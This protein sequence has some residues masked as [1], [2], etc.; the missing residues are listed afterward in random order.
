MRIIYNIVTL[1][2]FACGMLHA[3]VAPKKGENLWCM[4]ERIGFTSDEILSKVCDIDSY[5]PLDC[6]SQSIA[7]EILMKVCD[8][9]NQNK[10][11]I[12]GTTIAECRE[13]HIN[14]KFQ[15]GISD[16]QVISQT[17]DS[18]VI[19][20]TTVPSM[21]CLELNT[22]QTGRATITSRR[23]IRYRAGHES[24]AV[25]SAAFQ[26]PAS[27]STQWIGAY[28]SVDGAAVGYAD[29]GSFAVLYRVDSINNVINQADFN[30]DTL[31][32]AGPSG[33]ILNPANINIFRISFGWLGA[34]PIQYQIFTDEGKWIVFHEIA[35]TN[36]FTEPSFTN[37]V[38]P[39]QAEIVGAA[40]DADIK[41]CTACWDG[42]IIGCPSTAGHRFFTIDRFSKI[43]GGSTEQA[44]L[45]IR[46]RTTFNGVAN[47]TAVRIALFGGGILQKSNDDLIIRL[48]KNATLTSPGV[49][50]PVNNTNSVI[51]QFSGTSKLSSSGTLVLSTGRNV[52]G[53]GPSI[54]FLPKNGYVVILEPGE[55][56]SFTMEFN[57]NGTREFLSVL[58]WEELF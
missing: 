47:K 49:F 5:F 39:M 15:Y 8:I 50:M 25:F 51:E 35:R 23:S 43:S 13:D 42:G 32:G 20:T 28:N 11:S 40:V 9:K 53:T 26:G 30:K 44:V 19:S 6:A 21:V 36:L 33:F 41:L 34:S 55:T 48:R 17:V 22:G 14:I 24:F 57:S 54:Q 1:F 38:L 7:D 3:Q 27:A 58:G 56:L 29:S 37:P 4:S 12:F 52:D 2:V 31:D 16:S 18:G 10:K 45:T 46:N